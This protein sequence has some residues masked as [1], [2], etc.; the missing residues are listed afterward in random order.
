MPLCK[1]FVINNNSHYQSRECRTDGK[2]VVLRE[3]TQT[4]IC[5]FSPTFLTLITALNK[6][7]QISKYR[8]SPSVCSNILCNS[9]CFTTTAE[10]Q[11][12]THPQRA[13]TPECGFRISPTPPMD[14]PV[15]PVL[16]SFHLLSPSG[17]SD[18]RSDPR[19]K[20]VP[21]NDDFAFKF[22]KLANVYL[23]A[24]IWPSK[25]LAESPGFSP[26]LK[27]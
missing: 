20:I 14:E 9:G 2:E 23:M 22:L 11:I 10:L 27:V 3:R 13:A 17:R 4:A 18:N 8:Q 15:Y 24:A 5:I 21:I 6:P 1:C 12:L 26:V 7:L 16:Q 19:K 25:T